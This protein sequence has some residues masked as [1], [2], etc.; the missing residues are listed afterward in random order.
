MLRMLNCQSRAY[1]YVFSVIKHSDQHTDTETLAAA[2]ASNFDAASCTS[3]NGI[4]EQ[5]C[6]LTS[7]TTLLCDK[8]GMTFDRRNDWKNHM[9]LHANKCRCNTCGK[10]FRNP[11]NL[12]D[13]KRT[14]EGILPYLCAQ[15]G[16]AFNTQTLLTV[17]LRTHTGERPF[18]CKYC[19]ASFGR[20]DRLHKHV[21]H[22]HEPHRLLA[23]E[24]CDR[25]FVLP[26]QLRDHMLQHSTE[27]SLRCNECGKY[28]KSKNSLWVHQRWQHRKPK[29][30]VCSDATGEEVTSVRQRYHQYTEKLPCPLCGRVI[31]GKYY[32]AVH[33]RRHSG[34]LPLQCD[35]CERGFATRAELD[36]HKITKHCPEKHFACTECERRYSTRNGLEQHLRTHTG[37]K[38]FKCKDCGESF[39]FSG[40]LYIHRQR[41]HNVAASKKLFLSDAVAGEQ[42]DSQEKHSECG[43]AVKQ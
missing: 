37:E 40:Q 10:Q 13:H 6:D 2:E 33:L 5:R 41:V 25:K 3:D 34:D 43:P 23:C 36:R 38:P 9:R 21:R 12:R 27:R 24:V 14:H 4:D 16:R 15:C 35:E 22:I 19:D 20:H 39:T 26:H 11:R 31:T 1:V 29:F 28:Y 8:C 18:R 42:N 17:H 32:L 30:Q 7:L